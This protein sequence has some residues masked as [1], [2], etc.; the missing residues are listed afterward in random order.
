MQFYLRCEA[1]P[2]KRIFATIKST[3]DT[4]NSSNTVLLFL[5]L[6]NSPNVYTLVWKHTNKWRNICTF[7]IFKIWDIFRIRGS[8]GRIR[9]LENVKSYMS[10]VQQCTKIIKMPTLKTYF[11]YI[12]SKLKRTRSQITSDLY[13]LNWKSSYDV[14][15]S[16][17]QSR[18][19]IFRRILI[20]VIFRPRD[21]QEY[22][23]MFSIALEWR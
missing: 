5:F 2:V 4:D 9:H 22:I 7:Q 6:W 13:I 16:M 23:F 21:M 10:Y 19:T 14:M 1:E 17:C 12:L 3:I 20:F 15:L 8:A 11:S 18:S